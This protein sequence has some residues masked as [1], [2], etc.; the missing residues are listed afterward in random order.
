MSPRA[1]CR[2]DTLGFEHVFDYMP[3]KADWLARGL[4]REGDKA[5]EPRAVDYARGDVVACALGDPAGPLRAAIEAS[6]YGFALVIDAAGVV[7][8]RLPKSTVDAAGDAAAEA[9]MEPGPSTV[10]AD[11][12]PHALRERLERSGY[13]DAVVTDPD[14]RLLGVARRAD[15][16]A[17]G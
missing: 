15:L 2:L 17:D 8:G 14:G 5:A 3:G 4:P 11:A 9:L 16:P 7:L 12:A 10:R 13:Q 6:P 1:A